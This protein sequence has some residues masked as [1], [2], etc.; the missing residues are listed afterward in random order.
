MTPEELVDATAAQINALGAIYY[1]HPDTVAYGKEELG[2]DGM[3]FYFLGRGGVLGD[4][5]ASIATAAF[6]Y[7]A[8]QVM[9]KMWKSSRAKVAPRRAVK[10]ALHSN[11]EIGRKALGDMPE[12]AAFCDAAEQVVADADPAGLRIYGG[13]AVQPLPEDLPGRAMQLLVVHRELRGDVHL[14]AVHAAGIHPKIAH[15]IRRPNDLA[16]F[17]WPEDVSVTDNDRARLD[18]VDVETD[19]MSAQH[20]SSLSD[21]QRDAFVAG[22][23]AIAEVLL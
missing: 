17:G 22:V 20:Y 19:A 21:E 1:F 7:F 3:R 16:A 11:A 8:P 6:G 15:A 5:S 4:V 10:A 23:N 18:A 13:L 12:L 2:L 9:D 14:A